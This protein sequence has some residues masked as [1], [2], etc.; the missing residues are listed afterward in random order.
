MLLADIPIPETQPLGGTPEG[1]RVVIG[2][3][4]Y[5]VT[6]AALMV[7]LWWKL[8]RKNALLGDSARNATE[9]GGTE[10]EGAQG[11]GQ[12]SESESG[13]DTTEES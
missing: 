8:P 7:Y 12:E 1:W 3:L 2:I 10:E 13:N 11:S 4:V 6:L 5:I 9:K